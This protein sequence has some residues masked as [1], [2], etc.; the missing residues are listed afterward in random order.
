[1]DR[2]K[3]EGGGGRGEE[4]ERKTA[5]NH[6]HKMFETPVRQATGKIS[7]P[8][9]LLSVKNNPPVSQNLLLLFV[10]VYRKDKTERKELTICCQKKCRNFLAGAWI[11]CC[12]YRKAERRWIFCCSYRKAERRCKAAS[13]WGDILAVLPTGFGKS[14]IFQLFLEIKEMTG[15]MCSALVI[16]PLRSIIDDQIKEAE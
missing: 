14:S 13:K 16:T 5:C 10:K 6:P 2:A 8:I 12:S 4:K 7:F 9:G 15:E 3:G 1:M 11:F